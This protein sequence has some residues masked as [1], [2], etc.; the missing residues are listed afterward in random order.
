VDDKIIQFEFQGN[1]IVANPNVGL[2]LTPEIRIT[3]H[4]IK[5]AC[6]ALEI[7]F[8]NQT[9]GTLSAQAKKKYDELTKNIVK[10]DVTKEMKNKVKAKFNNCCSK[11]GDKNNLEI[12]HIVALV[13]G[14]DNSMNNLNLLCK[15]CHKEKTIA[16]NSR[17]MVKGDKDASHSH[18]NNEVLDIFTGN[19]MKN[20][21]KAFVGKVSKKP[22]PKN[23]YFA[24]YDIIKCY[25]NAMTNSK[26]DYPVYNAFDKPEPFDGKLKTG[27]YYISFAYKGVGGTKNR[28][29]FRGSGWY[30]LPSV[31]Y[32]IEKGMIAK[33]NIRFQLLPSD[34]IPSNFFNGFTEYVYGKCG[35]ISKLIIN[36]FI[37]CLNRYQKVNKTNV[38]AFSE[39]EAAYYIHTKKFDSCIL[40]VLADDRKMWN[41]SDKHITTNES[42]QIPIYNYVIALANV[43][44]AKLCDQMEEKGG[45]ILAIRTDSVYAYFPEKIKLGLDKTLYRKETP[46]AEDFT[47]IKEMKLM[48]TSKDNFYLK[49]RKWNHMEVKEDFK[50]L[51]KD[52]VNSN[53]SIN[54]DGQ[55][56]T[57]K[58]YLINEIIKRLEKENKSYICL[59]PTN[60]ARLNLKNGMTL[61][62]FFLG[63]HS[64]TYQYI[65]IDEISMIKAE[66]YQRLLHIKRNST[67]KFILVGDFRQLPPVDDKIKGMN[68]KNSIP[69]HDL[70]DS[71]RLE[72]TKNRRS[73]SIVWNLAQDV[74]KINP[75]DFPANPCVRN[76]CF[77][78]TCRKEVNATEMK[79]FI[80]G[81]NTVFFKASN[82][83]YSQEIDLCIGMPVIA[84]KSNYKIKFFNGETYTVKSIGSQVLLTDGQDE[85]TIDSS[86]FTRYFAPAF[87]V[88]VHKSQGETINEPYC[89][90]EWFKF[91]DKMKYVA[92]TRTTKKEYINIKV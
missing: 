81:K 32:G 77:T 53:K 59:A 18:L 47:K 37:G 14:G 30:A 15:S 8:E 10:R 65:I 12:D 62:M 29:P 85:K 19:A 64:K 84:Y 33:D 63:A 21:H 34:T 46:H 48:D 76:I 87:C 9:V 79:K 56:G 3:A 83:I 42:F 58:T 23:S 2:Y 67:T 61:H 66:F 27:F 38:L 82:D 75:H 78:N 60:K 45:K 92:L 40:E 52:I 43:N 26:Y 55:A 17:R 36:T 13:D 6:D 69:M 54:I 80:K 1:I 41:I 49:K 35:I 5:E 90:W 16:D 57:G 44:V 7:E 89:I 4:I 71:N 70:S 88:T 72:L 24:Q 22:I 68:Y 74:N 50:E 25:K 86:Q 91:S 39:H 28:I 73:D 20:N 11:C 51:A 31:E